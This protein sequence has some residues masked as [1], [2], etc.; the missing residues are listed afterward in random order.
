II[1]L[2]TAVSRDG[3]LLAREAHMVID[4]GAYNHQ[5]PLIPLVFPA[6][7]MLPY[8]QEAIRC[9]A[10]RVYTNKSP[11]SAMRG[12]GSPQIH[13][14][15]DV[16]MDLIGR[17]LGMDPLELRLKNGL[18]TG[19]T[20]ISGFHIYSSGFRE[21]LRLARNAL[22]LQGIAGHTGS[23]GVRAPTGVEAGG[24]LAGWGLGCSGFPCGTGRR[25]HSGQEAYS[26]ATVEAHE[27][28]SVTLL[29]GAADLGQGSNTTLS[30]IVAEE[31]AVALERVKIV[32]AD[33]AV[34]PR[35]LGAYSS[36][37]TMMA[38][39]AA[40]R[41]ARRVKEQLLEATAQALEA[42]AS[43][44]ALV[45]GR[46]EVKGS[47]ERGLSFAGA[48][49]AAHRSSAGKPVVGEGSFTPV[50]SEGSPSWSFGTNAA[51]VEIDG[52]TG[53]ILVR[54]MAVARDSGVEIN[55][56]AVEGQLEGSVHMGIGFALTEELRTQ[57]GQV[58]NP[59]LLD[60]K[61]MT[62]LEMPAIDLLPVDIVDP[63]GPFGAKEVGEGAV[64][65]N[66]PAIANAL[67]Q[68]AGI[69]VKTL[70]IVAEWVLEAL[71][72]RHRRP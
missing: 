71:E 68:A 1:R 34:T 70:P 36:R 12:F 7:F 14:A 11:C 23:R 43:D 17:D 50:T 2:K 58:L 18:E 33:T 42:N 54:R 63:V 24:A 21:T 52:D 66:A 3:R 10:V 61:V 25:S 30:Q 29:T 40:L 45:G 8:R 60:Y 38:G 48:V 32:S 46:I 67:L 62:P 49:V 56:L 53:E 69:E 27:D 19:D 5:G 13:F 44:L 64:G 37:T 6:R 51:H 35:D 55:P 47:P 72:D 15:Q 9:E 59:S 31:L 20:T 22:P 4:G 16:Q 65:P 41:A 57:D 28:G 26:G 39:N